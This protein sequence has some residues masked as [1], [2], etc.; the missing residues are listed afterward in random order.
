[1]RILVV[2]SGG[3]EH[4]LCWT[5]A[6]SPLCD[7]GEHVQECLA[8]AELRLDSF[9][10]VG[11]DKPPFEQLHGEGNHIGAGHRIQPQ[12]VAEVVKSLLLPQ[13][14]APDPEQ[15]GSALAPR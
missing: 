2:G 7:E 13:T 15:V 3:R 12:F 8:A 5:I 14:A 4:A 11:S 9:G 6:A 10:I 1:M